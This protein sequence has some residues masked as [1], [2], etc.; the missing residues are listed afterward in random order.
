MGWTVTPKSRKDIVAAK[1]KTVSARELEIGKPM[2][3]IVMEVGCYIGYTTRFL[4]KNFDVVACIEMGDFFINLSQLY[5]QDRNNIV[6]MR[7]ASLAADYGS[8]RRDLSGG[9]PDEQVAVFFFLDAAHD[10]ISVTQD[11]ANIRTS[12]KGF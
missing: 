2:L 10:W 3:S 7:G 8:L 4:S 11:V 12:D 1:E 9:G 5:N 6:W